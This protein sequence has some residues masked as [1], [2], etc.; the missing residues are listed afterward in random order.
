MDFRYRFTAGFLVIG[1]ATFAIAIFVATQSARNT[2]EASLVEEISGK[3]TQNAELV[4]GIV[5]TFTADGSLVG[6]PADSAASIGFETT[7]MST[8]LQ[9]SDIVSLTLFDAQGSLLWTSAN[10][11]S[12][13]VSPDS[14]KFAGALTGEIV[15]GLKRNVD[16]VTFDGQVMSGD[17]ASTYIPLVD[18]STQETSQ[19]LEVARE[20]TDA[21]DLRVENAQDSMLSTLFGTLGAS[22]ALL[23][24]IVIAAD[25]IINRSRR[26]ALTQERAAT[27]SKVA[28]ERLELRNEQLQ[29]M[30]EERDKFLSMVS[31]E[32]RTPLTSMLAFT[33]VLRRRQDGSNKEANLDQLDLMRRNGD[34][35]DSL[36]A[37]LLEVTTIHSA[38][39]EIVKEN[40]GLAGLA[41]VIESSASPL[42][43][44]KHQ[45]L[46]INCDDD[47]GEFYAD[48]KRIV[49]LI[50]NL[51]NNSSAY[52][53]ENTTITIDME[54]QGH[55]I[56]LSVKDQGEGISPEDQKRLFDQFYRGNSE[57]SRA[58]SGLGLGLPIVKA[59]VDAHDG[60]ISVR[61]QPGSGTEVT[62]LIPAAETQ[63]AAA[64]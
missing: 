46:R 57:V 22:F 5:N 3:S 44:E 15:T 10:D 33:E 37:E 47:G 62:V 40:F 9:S 63:S 12:Y 26:R 41:E 55:L 8:L 36:I 49:Q 31:H 56:K 29:Q 4:T 50:M 17:L 60:K 2:E 45:K 30:A 23:F 48:R 64:A 20:V 14:S 42:L 19:V 59:I 35:L 32:L 13:T 51:V 34:H 25:I 58:H 43:A 24:G 28:A 38:E 6:A 7:V 16:F 1:I 52:S 39:F 11:T 61:S 54:H 27:E 53:P 21:L 18:Q